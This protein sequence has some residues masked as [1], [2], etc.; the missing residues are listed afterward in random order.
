MSALL[1]LV[2]AGVVAFFLY[3]IGANIFIVSAIAMLAYGLI[4]WRTGIGGDDKE[5]IR[6][7]FNVSRAKA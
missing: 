1:G 7:A 6:K 5:L 3:S 4:V 2:V